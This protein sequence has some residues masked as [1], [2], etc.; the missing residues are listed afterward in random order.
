MGDNRR[1]LLTN[2]DGIASKGLAL[3][4]DLVL[5]MGFSNV[6]VVAPKTDKTAAS[7][8]LSLQKKLS[9]EQVDIDTFVVDGT[10]VDC[11]ITAFHHPKLIQYGQPELVFSGVNVGP[12]QEVDVLYSGTVSAAMQGLLFGVP[13]FALSQFCEADQPIVWNVKSDYLENYILNTLKNQQ[14]FDKALL[15]INLPYRK[16]IGIKQIKQYHDKQHV[17]QKRSFIE[18]LEHTIDNK[19]YL[20]IQSIRSYETCPFVSQGYI[21]VAPIGYDL[22]QLQTLTMLDELGLER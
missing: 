12:N 20:T 22:T 11:V 4:K 17:S 15:N 3:L 5:D 14:L 7:H 10:P 18:I 1:V 19:E 21:T 9:I 16:A 2:D 8:A 6:V 13:A